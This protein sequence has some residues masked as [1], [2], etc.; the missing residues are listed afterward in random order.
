MLSPFEWQKYGVLWPAPIW[1][2]LILFDVF[3]KRLVILRFFDLFLE[4]V[5]HGGSVRP[6]QR[7]VLRIF[8]GGGACTRTQSS[9]WKNC[10]GGATRTIFWANL[11]QRPADR[12]WHTHSDL[13][14]FRLPSSVWCCCC[15]S[16]L[17]YCKDSE[18][19]WVLNSLEQKSPTWHDASLSWLRQY[20]DSMLCNARI[21]MFGNR[22]PLSPYCHFFTTHWTFSFGSK[23]R[24]WG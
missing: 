3:F 5:G 17:L 9:Q 22:L 20:F 11:F 23:T 7:R 2:I 12:L 10:P 14:G 16:C 19:Y 4:S 1:T 15:F 8:V 6:P 24:W 21:D 18:R 13:A